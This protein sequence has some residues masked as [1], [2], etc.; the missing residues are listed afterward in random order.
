MLTDQLEVHLDQVRMP[1][2]NGRMDKKTKGMSLDVMNAIKNS[3]VVLK[4][5]FLCMA[6]AIIIAMARINGDPMD[7]LYRDGNVLKKN[8]SKTS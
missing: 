5:A 1:A 3:I 7:G 2:G 4:T 8:L 6:H